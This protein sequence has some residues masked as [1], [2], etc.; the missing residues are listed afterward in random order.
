MH[1]AL[2]LGESSVFYLFTRYRFNW[3]EIE[4]SMYSTYA[5]IINT[6]GKK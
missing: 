4:Y 3:S 1:S 5:E 6:T 2:F